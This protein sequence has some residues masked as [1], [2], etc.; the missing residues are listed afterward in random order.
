LAPS[1]EEAAAVAVVVVAAVGIDMGIALLECPLLVGIV[2]IVP[3]VLLDTAA[4][5]SAL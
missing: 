3:P 5:G 4:Q 1:V 2:D